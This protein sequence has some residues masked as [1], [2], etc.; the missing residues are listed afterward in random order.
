MKAL[1]YFDW[2]SFKVLPQ[3]AANS[4]LKH[5]YKQNKHI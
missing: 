4:V 5:N 1:P 3:I 2:D